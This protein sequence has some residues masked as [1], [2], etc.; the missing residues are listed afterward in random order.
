MH[1]LS[2]P[3]QHSLLFCKKLGCACQLRSSH[4]QTRSRMVY[5][6]SV[7]ACIICIQELHK[8]SDSSSDQKVKQLTSEN[9]MLEN[10]VE[11][12]KMQNE[13]LIKVHS[14]CKLNRSVSE[15][16]IDYQVQYIYDTLCSY[17][18][19]SGIISM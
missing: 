16:D 4:K 1:Q 18:C 5:M 14:K 13:Q 11:K 3:Q 9:Q 15:S 12:L 10:K 17:A 19:I 6:C 7:H 8:G 2:S